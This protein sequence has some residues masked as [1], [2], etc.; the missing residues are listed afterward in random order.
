[1]K[2]RNV[3][4]RMQLAT[5]LTP[6]SAMYGPKNLGDNLSFALQP[7]FLGLR[8]WGRIVTSDKPCLPHLAVHHASPIFAGLHC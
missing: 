1:M 5:V 8:T 2:L 4:H 3:E 6:C 7:K